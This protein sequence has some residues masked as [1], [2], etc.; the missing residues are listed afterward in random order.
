M[1]FYKAKINVY[2]N[3][4]KVILIV[5]LLVFAA[6]IATFFQKVSV[7]SLAMLG[8]VGI[9]IP[10]NRAA[11]DGALHWPT[12]AALVLAGL[13]MSSRLYLNVHTPR[14][15]LT[16]AIIGFGVSFLGMIFLFH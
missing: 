16:G 6:T 5:A 14:E 8:V 1:F 13:V 4:N 10:L 11:E 7:H 9:L 3:F 12:V 2:V 15:V